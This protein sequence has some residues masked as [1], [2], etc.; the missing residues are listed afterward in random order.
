[1]SGMFKDNGLPDERTILSKKCLKDFGINVLSVIENDKILFPSGNIY[2]S[3]FVR[4][5]V[6]AG[7]KPAVP[8]RK[9]SGFIVVVI[10]A[11]N[12][13]APYCKFADS[14][15]VR[16]KDSA[17]G[18]AYAFSNAFAVADNIS[19]D[20]NKGRSLR[21]PV[22]DIYIEAERRKEARPFAVHRR[23]AN[24]HHRETVAEAFAY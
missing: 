6:I 10:A 2:V 11:C 8:E 12:V 22:A 15:G 16:R 3:L 7:Q 17:F 5:A 14:V 20:G 1:M 21:Q 18:A 4:S 9:G 19:V 24:G 23:S 13:A